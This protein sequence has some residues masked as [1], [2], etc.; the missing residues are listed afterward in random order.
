[1]E[2]GCIAALAV[3]DEFKERTRMRHKSILWIFG[4]LLTSVVAL[5]L[6]SPKGND[7]RE[8]TAHE[9][10]TF[11]SVAG[12][13]GQAVTWR[14][15][16]DT[17][18]LPCFVERFGGFKGGLSSTVRME[19]PVLYFYGPRASS[20]D[21]K[22]QFP[23]GTIT[24][25]YPKGVT[26]R[27]Y[28][29]LEWTDV[30]ITP[31]SNQEFP[32]SGRSHYFSARATDAAPLKVGSQ[33]EKFL[34]Y[35]GA[36]TFAL[37][38][39]AK[40]ANGS[41]AMQSIGEDAIHQTVVFE[42]RGGV[43]RFRSLGPLKGDV[44][45]N[46]QSLGGNFDGLLAELEHVL[47]T[48]GLYPKEAHAMVETWRDSWFEEGT[49]VFYIVPRRVIDSVLPLQIQPVPG[50]VERVFVGRMEIITPAIQEEVRAAIEK[51]DRGTLMKYGRFLEPIAK[52]IGVQNAF[53][54]TV[55]DAY[56][57][58]GLNCVK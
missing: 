31:G 16:S 46:M 22:V 52:R 23:K 3:T 8:L 51:Q 24:E 53:V 5:A 55:Y 50:Q 12:E 1:M 18:D 11:T 30:S 17:S 47:V 4:L 43:R 33:P 29:S 20:V 2:A 45:V 58:S 41:L 19:T 49:R 14:T 54:N 34:F 7:S 6:A 37:P 42:N 25:W 10:G 28:D 21:V 27:S 32:G 26:S 40:I 36:G 39:S 35:R 44:T 57:S 9:W 48:E 15:F 13:N 38:L 56:L